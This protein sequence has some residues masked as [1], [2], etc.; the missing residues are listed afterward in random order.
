MTKEFNSLEELKPYYKKKTNTYV[1]RKNGE[2]LDV[3]FNFELNIDA[4]IEAR[5]IDASNIIAKNIKSRD[6]HARNIIARDIIASDIDTRGVH[7]SNIIFAGDIIANNID[8]WDIDAGDIHTKNIDARDIQFWAV[9]VAYEN[10][11]CD[12]IKPQRKKHII[13]A[14]DGEIIKRRTK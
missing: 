10:I 1:L 8:A 7:T 14:L 9:C 5:D 12:C 6:I 2:L 13:K 11:K 3:K 4:N